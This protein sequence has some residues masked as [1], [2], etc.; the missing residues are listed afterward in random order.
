MSNLNMIINA[1]SQAIFNNSDK[2]HSLTNHSNNNL[3]VDLNFVVKL[4]PFL[5]SPI[6]IGPILKK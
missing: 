3:T 6:Q 5:G 4:K 1:A 2:I